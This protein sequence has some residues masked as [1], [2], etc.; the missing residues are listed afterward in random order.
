MGYHDG[1]AAKV[2]LEKF[3]AI[4]G[5][6]HGLQGM[7]YAIDSM[8]GMEAL[9]KDV[10]EF[11]EFAKNHSEKTFFVTLIGC[12]I[13]GYSPEEMAPLFERC[14]DL[15]NVCLPSEFWDIIG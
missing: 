5:Q 7:S 1:G 4:R 3:G 10:D 6:G 11:I 14:Y 12:G 15:E 9:K 8:S 13:A 2:A